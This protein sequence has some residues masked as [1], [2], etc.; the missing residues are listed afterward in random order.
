[1]TELGPTPAPTNG[2]LFCRTCGKKSIK[3][4]EGSTPDTKYVCQVCAGKP[5]DE[6]RFQGRSHDP[7]LRARKHDL[8]GD[9]GSAPV[10]QQRAATDAEQLLA[11]VTADG[12]IQVKQ[13]SK[14][15]KDAPAWVFDD[16]FLRELTR[17]YAR[18]NGGQ[19]QVALLYLYYRCGVKQKTLADRFGFKSEQ[20]VKK[21]IQ[22]LRARAEKYIEKT[23]SQLNQ[24][25]SEKSVP[26]SS[27]RGQIIV[28]FEE[29]A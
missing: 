22:R 2:R 6:I 13:K 21:A 29:V 10:A 23:S 26:S 16:K 28:E 9:S 14:P 24:G 8:T 15:R 25:L 1:M 5:P 17:K 11:E 12:G 20:A 7:Y 18:G 27:V 3:A 4:P 19:T